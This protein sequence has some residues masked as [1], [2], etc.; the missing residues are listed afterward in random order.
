M[1][2]LPVRRSAAGEAH[3]GVAPRMAHRGCASGPWPDLGSID[4]RQKILKVTSMVHC[5]ASVRDLVQLPRTPGTTTNIPSS[6][7]MISQFRCLKGT[8]SSGGCR[9]RPQG[10]E[11]TAQAC[12]I[13][14]SRPFICLI[15]ISRYNP[16]IGKSSE[17]FAPRMLFWVW[18]NH[19][20][21]NASFNNPMPIPCASPCRIHLLH[22]V[23]TGS[24]GPWERLSLLR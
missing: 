24:H 12:K 16:Q 9:M 1:C 17:L 20:N 18:S 6:I 7:T 3:R 5:S 15:Y 2:R 14:T 11:R 13:R 10:R 22:W 21:A 4:F 19:A 23:A 8:A